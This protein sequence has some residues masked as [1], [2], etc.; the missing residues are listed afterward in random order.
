M[1]ETVKTRKAAK[2]L[3]Q[4]RISLDP[5]FP[6]VVGDIVYVVLGEDMF[7]VTKIKPAKQPYW[8]RK[9]LKRN[10]V[11]RGISLPQAVIKDLGLNG[12]EN[13]E[14]NYDQEKGVLFYALNIPRS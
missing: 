2:V 13:F 12:G 10:K 9:V 8:E 1:R 6:V 14:V 11:T 3:S 5:M 7:A 4:I